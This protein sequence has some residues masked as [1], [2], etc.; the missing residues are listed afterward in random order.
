MWSVIRVTSACPQC[1]QSFGGQLKLRGCESLC[2]GVIRVHV[3]MAER[4]ALTAAGQKCGHVRDPETQILTEW[5][6]QVKTCCSVDV[7]LPFLKRKWRHLRL[8]FLL[9]S[10]H[11]IR[12]GHFLL[13]TELDW[14]FQMNYDL[15]VQNKRVLT[16]TSLKTKRTEQWT[17]TLTTSLVQDGNLLSAAY[18]SFI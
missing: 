10:R 8:Y 2:W 3:H 11:K 1:Q 4:C 6:V 9:C 16:E 18:D 14:L 5:G 15:W 13:I 12:R 17:S 7:I